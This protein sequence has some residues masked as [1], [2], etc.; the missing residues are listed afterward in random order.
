MGRV[1]DNWINKVIGG[2]ETVWIR[3]GWNKKFPFN[4]E[5]YGKGYN[6]QDLANFPF[7]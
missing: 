4:E 7:Y 6:K 3:D 5:D 1:E 2:N